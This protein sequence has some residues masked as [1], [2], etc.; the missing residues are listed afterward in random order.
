LTSRLISATA[1]SRSDEAFGGPSLLEV[2]RNEFMRFLIGLRPHP[3]CTNRIHQGAASPFGEE[4]K[5][6]RDVAVIPLD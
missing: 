2:R 5:L 4:R 3:L 1:I 6:G